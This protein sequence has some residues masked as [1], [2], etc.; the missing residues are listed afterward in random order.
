[1]PPQDRQFIYLF[2]RTLGKSEREL[3]LDRADAWPVRGE[4]EMDAR[5]REMGRGKSKKSTGVKT[6]RKDR[7]TR[8]GRSEVGNGEK[9]KTK[10]AP[11]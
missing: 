10:A 5:R 3:P 2:G 6:P 9:N 4:T 7:K 11:A 1:M 8:F